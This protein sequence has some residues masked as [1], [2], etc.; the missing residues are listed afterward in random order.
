MGSRGIE[1]DQVQP[2]VDHGA[3]RPAL[4]PKLVAIEMLEVVLKARIAHEA[5][6]PSLV[7]IASRLDLPATQH[8]LAH[9]GRVP[10]GCRPAPG[11]G[12]GCA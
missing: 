12:P 3:D 7:A 8:Y 4:A 6:Q 11:R 1:E 9:F 2:P 10:C 5:D